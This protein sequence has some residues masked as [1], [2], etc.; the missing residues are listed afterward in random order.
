ME[1]WNI[2]HKNSTKQFDYEQELFD[3]AIY[4]HVLNGNVGRKCPYVST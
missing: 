2:F 1:G 3:N 4:L